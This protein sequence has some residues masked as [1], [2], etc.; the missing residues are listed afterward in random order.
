[1]ESPIYYCKGGTYHVS[2][3]WQIDTGATIKASLKV[4]YNQQYFEGALLY[5][6]QRK[7]AIKTDNQSDNRASSIEN[8]A[9]N[10]CLLVALNAGYFRCN[11]YVCLMEF[12]DNFALDEGKLWVLYEKYNHEFYGNYKDNIITWLM[13]DGTVIETKRDITPGSE[14]KL[15]IIISEGIRSYKME[16]SMEIN[17]KRLVLSLSMLIVLMCAVSLSN[18]ILFNIHNQCLNVDLVSPIYAV[19]YML[20]YHSVPDYKVCAGDT[21]RSDFIIINFGNESRGALIYRLQRKQTHKS[22]EFDKDT[23]SATHL[24]VVWKFSEFDGLHANVLLVEHD[25]EIDKVL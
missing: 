7:Y 3:S 14:Y 13:D 8:T 10:M 23:S 12:T 17:P 20:E 16:R 9:T 4:G 2:P 1:L 5:K 6:L 11:F 15:D 21:T 22:I 19:D 25:K 18:H 24:L